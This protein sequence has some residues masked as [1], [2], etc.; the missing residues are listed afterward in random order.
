MSWFKDMFGTA[1]YCQQ[2]MVTINKAAIELSQLRDEVSNLRRVNAH[3]ASQ[4]RIIVDIYKNTEHERSRD[5]Y[6]EAMNGLAG[7]DPEPFI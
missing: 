3:M 1:S 4:L 6:R 7:P 2:H 5:M